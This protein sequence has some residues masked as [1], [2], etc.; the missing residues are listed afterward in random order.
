[1]VARL[2]RIIEETGTDIRNLE[3]QDNHRREASLEKSNEAKLAEEADY[4]RRRRGILTEGERAILEEEDKDEKRRAETRK[5]QHDA[6]RQLAEDRDTL[7]SEVR[8]RQLEAEG[9]DTEAR[10]EA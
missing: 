5:K 2:K 10:I 4:Q 9:K 8:Q 1:Y 6:D 3:Q 7:A